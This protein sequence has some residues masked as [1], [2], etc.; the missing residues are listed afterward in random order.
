MASASDL[1]EEA[2]EMVGGVQTCRRSWADGAPTAPPGP[3]FGLIRHALY[4]SVAASPGPAISSGAH[5]GG[6]VDGPGAGE[7]TVFLALLIRREL[8]SWVEFRRGIEFLCSC[9]CVR[10]VELARHSLYL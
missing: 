1:G 2:G 5:D 9:V 4:A 10:P 8:L 6:G 7:W 3:S